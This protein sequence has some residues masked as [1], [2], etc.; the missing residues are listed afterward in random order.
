MG[1]WSDVFGR[2]LPMF[3]PGKQIQCFQ[4]THI[5]KTGRLGVGGV[6]SSTVYLLVVSLESM[7]VE[8]LCLASFLSGQNT[9][10]KFKHSICI[11][12]GIFGGVTSVI[13]NCFSYVAALAEKEERTLR[14][15]VVEGMQLVAAMA[16]PFLSKLIKQ[17][18]GTRAVFAGTVH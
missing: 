6:L 10:A 4:K 1:G 3:L 11:V 13:A 14:V 16:G 17:Q 5:Q 7:A 15:S 2:K 8:W 9:S 12:S 18:L